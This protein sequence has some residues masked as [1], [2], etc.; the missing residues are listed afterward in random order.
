MSAIGLDTVRVLVGGCVIVARVGRGGGLDWGFWRLGM[1][2][3]E[4]EILVLLSYGWIV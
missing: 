2:F 3:L 4:A 1:V